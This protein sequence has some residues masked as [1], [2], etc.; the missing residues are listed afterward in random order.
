MNMFLLNKVLQYLVAC[1]DYTDGVVAAD[2]QQL[3]VQV[4][5]QDRMVQPNVVSHIHTYTYKKKIRIYHS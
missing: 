5:V 4:F 1:T 2:T 3:V